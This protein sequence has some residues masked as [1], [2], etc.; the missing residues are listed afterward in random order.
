MAAKLIG[1]E[2]VTMPFASY[3][4]IVHMKAAHAKTQRQTWCEELVWETD[5]LRIQTVA[6]WGAFHYN[7]KDWQPQ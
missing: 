5:P 4:R 3:P 1:A 6:Q 7:V 2:L